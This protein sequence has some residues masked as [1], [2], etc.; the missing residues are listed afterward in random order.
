MRAGPQAPPFCL[1]VRAF[2]LLRSKAPV[3][4][5]K[6]V[7]ANI[8]DVFYRR[9]RQLLPGKTPARAFALLE[10]VTASQHPHHA[11]RCVGWDSSR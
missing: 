6:Q 8:W 1:P 5:T 9:R 4:Q 2:W 7:L 11:A 10:I 3:R